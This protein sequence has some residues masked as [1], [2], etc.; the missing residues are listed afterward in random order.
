VTCREVADFLMEYLEG[1]LNDREREVFDAHL[2]A[3]PGCVRYLDTY[4]ETVRLGKSLC[5]SN[6]EVPE[7]VPDALVQAILSARSHRG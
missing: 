2:H 7:N 6:D 1:R 3:C 5:G 4:R